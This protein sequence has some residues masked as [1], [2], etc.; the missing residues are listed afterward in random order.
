MQNKDVIQN[1]QISTDHL[2]QYLLQFC[3]K[4]LKE[5]RKLDVQLSLYK[6][7]QEFRA[8]TKNQTYGLDLTK[9]DLE[10]FYNKINKINFKTTT[11]VTKFK[12]DL[13]LSIQE[14]N[15]YYDEETGIKKSN[16]IK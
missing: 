16:I 12:K 4:L 5:Q 7:C 13:L 11:T 2:K 14:F 10:I 15:N 3:A 1:L 6:A 9:K 8:I